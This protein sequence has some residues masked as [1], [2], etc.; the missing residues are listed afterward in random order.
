[1][2]RLRVSFVG[3]GNAGNFYFNL[4]Q[5]NEFSKLVSFSLAVD[6]NGISAK[7]WESEKGIK[8]ST[9]INEIDSS[10]TDL[11]I[12]TSPSGSHAE[13]SRIL[14]ANRVNVLCEK[15]I[16]LK[17]ND[18]EKNIQLAKEKNVQYGSVFQN[19]YN[20]PIEFAKKALQNHQLGKIISGSVQLQW[21][22]E[23]TYYNDGWHGTWKHDGGVINQQGIHHIDAL[24]FLLGDPNNIVGFEGNIS[25]DLEAEDTFV[26]AGTF[27]D[28]GFFTIEASTAL[29]PDD[30]KASI[31]IVGTKGQVGVGGTAMNELS[32]FNIDGKQLPKEL[33]SQNSETVTSGFGN[34]H[35]VLIN[36][37]LDVWEK[38]SKIILP[39]TASD[40]LRSLRIVHSLYSS[41]EQSKIVKFQDKNKS[42][43]LGN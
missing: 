38:E 40:A 2:S 18:V 8:S 30:L 28:S 5:S 21:C 14:L 29:R 15:P 12:I 43:R 22:R 23:Q 19:R 32:F 37:I 25:N 34:G 39:L 36:K 1:M 31:E 24:F 41:V 9:D 17:I 4:F 3:L 13:H 20:K 27:Q 6:I 16:G 10:N 35:K 26:A 7:K 11:A 33:L 42:L